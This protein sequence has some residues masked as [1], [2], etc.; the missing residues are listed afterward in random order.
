MRFPSGERA[1]TQPARPA[2]AAGRAGVPHSTSGKPWSARRSVSRR[3][4]ALSERSPELAARG[5]PCCLGF[6]GGSEM[7]ALLLAAPQPDPS[8]IAVTTLPGARP[9]SGGGTRSPPGHLQSLWRARGE[10]RPRTCPRARA[11]RRPAA[12]ARPALCSTRPAARAWAPAAASASALR[13]LQ[14]RTAMTPRRAA[15]TSGAAGRRALQ[16]VLERR[17]ACVHC[18]WGV[19]L[20]LTLPELQAFVRRSVRLSVCHFL[21]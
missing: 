12:A 20:M 6:P 8:G 21:V 15:V 4:A 10:G 5:A 11:Q 16:K 7:T 3:V 18:A 1:A 14:R 19:S 2:R 13:L 9:T 17:A